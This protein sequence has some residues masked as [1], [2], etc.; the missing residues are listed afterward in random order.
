MRN[1]RAFVLV[2]PDGVQR[3]LIGTVVSRFESRGLKIV[4]MR[5]L[6]LDREIVERYYAEHMEKDFFEDLV[7][8]ITSG[9]V[10]AMVVEGTDVVSVVRRMVG[11]TDSKEASPG[12]IRGDFGISKQ[13]NIIHAS[14]SPESAER[15]IP[16]FFSDDDIQEFERIDGPWTA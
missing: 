15:E 4:A 10:V 16:I 9:P 3:G 8:F 5:M 1:D 14:D 6:R 12:T 11:T 7:S 2:K 13:M